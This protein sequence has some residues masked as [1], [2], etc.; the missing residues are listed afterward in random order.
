MYVFLYECIFIHEFLYAWNITLKHYNILKEEK[1]I[2]HAIAVK[3][4]SNV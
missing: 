1:E 4:F 3:H 2:K